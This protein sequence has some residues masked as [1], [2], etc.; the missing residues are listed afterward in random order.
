MGECG[1]VRSEGAVGARMIVWV[2]LRCRVGDM[3]ER[4]VLEAGSVCSVSDAGIV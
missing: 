2:L 1:Y 3:D 4:H